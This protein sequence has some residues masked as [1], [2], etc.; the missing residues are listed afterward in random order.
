VASPDD[1][2]TR[3][4]RR[5]G[6]ASETHIG[7]GYVVRTTVSATASLELARALGIAHPIWAVVS[8]IVVI[9]PELKASIANALMRV[10][11]NLLGAGIG[12]GIA[13]LDLPLVPGLVAG[14]IAVAVCCRLLTIDAA[15]RSA[16]VALVIVLLR[17]TT[18]VLGSSE[19]RVALVMLGCVV[20]LV[21]TVGVAWST[22][23]LDRLVRRWRRAERTPPA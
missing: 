2:R 5:I 6:A 19:T 23:Q 3:L 12:V 18:G 21:V 13:A 15:S 10:V 16:G 22:P 1:W 4:A 8:S 9:V 20:S 14:L 17:D 7:P 11:A